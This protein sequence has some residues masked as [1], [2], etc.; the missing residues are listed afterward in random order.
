MDS[1]YSDALDLI[2]TMPDTSAAQNLAKLILSLHSDTC[3]YSL[4]EC[5][6]NTDGRARELSLSVIEHFALS[7]P[8]PRLFAAGRALAGRYPALWEVGRAMATARDLRIRYY[9]PT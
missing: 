7:G 1:P 5:L 9:T 4:R 6:A 8:E 2:E 3:A